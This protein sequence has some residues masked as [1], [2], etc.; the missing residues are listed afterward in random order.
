MKVC[1]GCFRVVWCV[2]FPVAATWAGCRP[3]CCW[4][5]HDVFA[6]TETDRLGPRWLSCFMRKSVSTGTHKHTQRHFQT[7]LERIG[8]LLPPRRVAEGPGCRC[9]G[10]QA[11][12]T[13]AESMSSLDSSSRSQAATAKLER[14]CH[15]T[16][17]SLVLTRL[18]EAQPLSRFPAH[19]KQRS[20]HSLL[21]PFPSK[22]I[23]FE[24]RRRPPGTGTG[25]SCT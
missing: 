3:V 25:K 13:L 10:S 2:D 6:A 23:D 20:P 7:L 21:G 9:A 4:Q 1:V 16:P 8:L 11:L 15:S 12:Q 18:Q 19:S 5:G 24:S 22:L 17:E 14:L